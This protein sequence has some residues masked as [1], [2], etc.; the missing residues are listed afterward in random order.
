MSSPYYDDRGKGTATGFHMRRRP[1]RRTFALVV[2]A[3]IVLVTLTLIV[4]VGTSTGADQTGIVPLTA[5]ASAGGATPGGA[6][7]TVPPKPRPGNTSPTPPVVGDMETPAQRAAIQKLI[8]YGMPIYC[9]GGTKPLVA[10]TFDDG[11][12]PYT[13]YTLD[14]LK[15]A[16]DEATFFLVGKLFYS[17]T[18]QKMAKTESKYGVVGDHTMTHIAL[19][20]AAPSVVSSEILH[21]Q[22]LIEKYTG[23]SV[24]LY[25]PPL[26]SHDAYVDKFVVNHNMLEVIW[27]LDS[28]D[29]L[30]ASTEQIVRNI[31]NEISPG[32]IIL[33]HE[34]RGTT[35]NALPQI[36]QIVADKGYKAVTVPELLAE[37]PPTHKQIKQ[38][39]CS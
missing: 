16:N 34:N 22:K 13:Q 5:L 17:S 12:G 14:T 35:R 9:G 7:A 29:S 3:L 39:S 8:D 6:Y 37:D 33:M 2:V 18:N 32:D 27:S 19:A 25:R 1:P 36:L 30:G 15:V 28:R 11:P 10:L 23:Q 31:Q 26:G 20:G 4:K 24:N 21:A 38:H